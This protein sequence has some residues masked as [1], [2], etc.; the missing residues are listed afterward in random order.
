MEGI[1]KIFAEVGG[2]VGILLVVICWM[3]YAN[4][5]ITN[6]L[7]KMIRLNDDRLMDFKK[8]IYSSGRL[9]RERRQFGPISTDV[10]MR[11]NDDDV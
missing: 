8:E 4:T 2:V 10:E 7:L 11:R 9:L 3:V 5:Q 1:V 6:S